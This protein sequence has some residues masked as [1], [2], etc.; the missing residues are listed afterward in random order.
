M[1]VVRRGTR[2][3]KFS[4]E[5]QCCRDLVKGVFENK[6]RAFTGANSRTGQ[7]TYSFRS[8]HSRA[9][10]NILSHGLAAKLDHS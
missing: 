5:N 8:H 4:R 7:Q 1:R 3:L 9:F 2:E 10:W 6:T